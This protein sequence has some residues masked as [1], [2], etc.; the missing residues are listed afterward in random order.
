[1][2]PTVPPTDGGLG[3]GSAGTAL[4]ITTNW[5][6]CP[7]TDGHTAVRLREEALTALP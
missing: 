5:P 7:C 1:M 4:E 6:D 2:K 3:P